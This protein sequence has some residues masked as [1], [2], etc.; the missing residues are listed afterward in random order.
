MKGFDGSGALGLLGI[1]PLPQGTPDELRRAGL[2]PEQIASCAPSGPGVRG[3][4]L[5]KECPFQLAKYG[6]F[7]YQGPKY[8]GFYQMTSEGN[9]REDFMLCHAFVR[10]MLARMREGNRAREEGRAHETIR[11]IAQEGD[12]VRQR[13]AVPVNPDDHTINARYAV[14]TF[15]VQVPE[16]PRPGDRSQVSY[17]QELWQDEQRRRGE[18]PEFSMG[19]ERLPEGLPDQ[20]FA[21][22]EEISDSEPV[23]AIAEPVM[24]GKK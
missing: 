19:M 21:D 8:V 3:C 7:K 23:Q 6:G 15:R 18:D 4:P 14:K 13:V 1:A 17:D 12:T 16:W 5:E 11:V 20:V 2:N 10:T 24:K 9:Q 22:L